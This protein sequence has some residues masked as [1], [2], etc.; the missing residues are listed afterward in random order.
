M[1]KYTKEDILRLAKEQNVR[2]VR[3]Q[4]TDILGC[5][6]N[7]AITINQLERALNNECMT[8]GSSIEGFVRV[9]ESDMY[10]YPDYDS[11]VVLPWE[12]ERFG[13]TARL[14]C[15]VYNADRTPFIGDPRNVLKR[16][17]E[18]ADKMGYTFNVGPELEFFLF[19]NDEEGRPTTKTH[20]RGGYFDLD[21]VDLGGNCRRDMCIALEDMGFEIEASHHEC[22][23]G[24]HEIDFKYGD[25]LDVADKVMT[26]KYVVKKYA[27]LHGLYATFLPKPIYGIAG[28]GMHTNMSL[29]DKDGN[30]A[31]Y[32]PDGE[33]GLSDTALHFIA[34][35]MKHIRAT[36]AINNPLVNSYKRLV[37]GYEAPVYIAW[38]AS[39]RSALVRV[40]KARGKGTRI[41]LRS[42]DPA[43]N[44]YLE[45]ALCLLAGLDGIE[46]GYMPP[47]STVKNIFD[48][49]PE[50]REEEGI[51]SLPG[52]LE[53]AVDAFEES[54]FIK[55]SLGE[56][57]YTKF[58]E[59][60][61]KEW[62]GYRTSISQWEIDTYLAK[63]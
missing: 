9:E 56:H 54:E 5:M 13:T 16:A 19:Y 7:V 47:K 62:E 8:D 63:Y 49:T 14:I 32:D 31:F 51:T 45:M 25:V 27:Q 48:M 15:D 2:F 12:H 11:F 6:K 58:I 53:E 44:P 61:R 43:C 40:P 46:K 55:E 34:G 37:P 30:N 1:G 28:S 60:K 26:F 57:V 24:Q 42:A 23:E 39:N 18:K 38:S 17:I 21:N 33:Y 29:F 59:A 20:D 41:E 35:I 3:L 10:L 36:T 50:E 52:S 22:A 4:F